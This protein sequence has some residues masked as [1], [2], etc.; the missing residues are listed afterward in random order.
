VDV[1]A[2]G[3]QW[4]GDRDAPASASDFGKIIHRPPRTVLRPTSAADV[5]DALR[6]IPRDGPAVAAQG[7]RHS[8]YGQ[9]LAGDGLVLDLRGLAAVHELL[10]DRV[11]VGAGR[12]W[13]ELLDVT[14]PAGSTPPV[15]T[16]YLDVTVGGTLAAGGV[17]GT[18]F[19]YGAQVDNIL[20]L[21]VVTGAGEIMTCSARHNREL[22]DAVRA[23]FGR[24]AIITRATLPLVRAPERVRKFTAGYGD[25]RSLN[26]ALR[27]LV[28]AG[29]GSGSGGGSGGDGGGSG[30]GVGG[31]PRGRADHVSAQAFPVEGGGWRYELAAAVYDHG[32][33]SDSGAPAGLAPAEV[34]EFG[35]LDFA[36]QMRPGV[37]E[38]QTLGEWDRP[39]P[40]LCLFVPDSRADELIERAMDRLTPDSMGL[41]GVVLI[42]PHRRDL[43]RAPLLRSPA[44]PI[45]FLL[46]LLRTASPGA[47]P[48]DQM[49]AANRALHDEVR[50]A[51]GTRYPID[52]VPF[53][54]GD[55]A[56]HYGTALDGLR[57]AKARFDPAGRLAPALPV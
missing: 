23:G 51:G 6:D 10:A 5:A 11:V 9:A 36:D 3:A 45:M 39:H 4:A 54:A 48:V 35:Y 2:S 43:M 49:V 53:T 1:A 34:E 46:G 7:C 41:S 22:F 8:T 17:G 50:A 33:G 44:E 16:D 27:R 26:A 31:A 12:T 56:D 40:W 14:V 38:L 20:E 42:N 28:A 30:R 29:D 55:W 37:A 25:V 19:R 13:R 32:T 15:L 57:A 18:S 21:E 24:C 52:A 47:Q